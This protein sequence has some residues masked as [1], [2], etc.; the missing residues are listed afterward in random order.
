MTR[1]RFVA[2]PSIF[3]YFHVAMTKKRIPSLARLISFG[4]LAAFMMTPAE[5]LQAQ[6]TR[7]TKRIEPEFDA[8][9]QHLPNFLSYRS[10]KRPKIAVVLSGGGARGISSI[11]VLKVLEEADIP[12]DLIVGTSIGS[13]LGGL[14]ASGYSIDQLQQMVDTTNWADVLSFN[15][16]ARRSDL[17]LDQKIAEDRSILTVRFEGLEPI[18]PQSLSTGQR[19]TNYLNLLVLQGIYHPSR[20]LTTCAFPSGQSRRTSLPARPWFSIAEISRRHFG[21]VFLFRFC[22][23]RFPVTPPGCLMADSFRISR[24]MPPELG[25]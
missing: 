14:Y 17:F 23:V 11:G 7:I 22:S 20:P 6:S 25:S 21:R 4:L 18:L 9:P 5:L 19:L 1:S 12:I 3:R 13:I 16:D 8:R 15:D 2:I 10:V 24:W